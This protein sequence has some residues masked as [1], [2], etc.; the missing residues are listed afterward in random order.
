MTQKLEIVLKYFPQ[1]TEDQILKFNLLSPQYQ[2]W[3]SLI[4]VFP[5]R[6][7][8]TFYEHQVLHSLAIAK[9]ISFSPG[10]TI[11][12]VG[13]GGGFP[14]IPLAILFPECNFTLI[15]SMQKR[16][17]VVQSVIDSIG[18]KNACAVHGKIEDYF[19]QFDFVVSRAVKEFPIFVG[20]VQKNFDFKMLSKNLNGILYLKGGSFEDE[21]ANLD[22]RIKVYEISDF[23]M[24]SYFQAK[25]IIYLTLD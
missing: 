24:E 8:E 9:V 5:E 13:T 3:T 19:E 15:D 17:K 4:K 25:K 1:L 16:I 7:F 10:S 21:L 23:F 18:L 22:G 2:Y 11:L 6:D 12:D 20:L 14:G